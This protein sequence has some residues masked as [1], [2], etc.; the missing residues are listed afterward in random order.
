MEDRGARNSGDWLL[1]DL[2]KGGNYYDEE[3]LEQQKKPEEPKF[4]NS[5]R[6]L[7]NGEIT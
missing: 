5:K 7:V 6:V 4:V 3:W 2:D 1:V